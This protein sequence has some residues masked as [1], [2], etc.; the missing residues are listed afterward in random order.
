D[1]R[2][3][4]GLRRHPG[5]PADY[6]WSRCQRKLDIVDIVAGGAKMRALRHARAHLASNF[7]V[8][9]HSARAAR[10]RREKVGP[11][12]RGWCGSIA[13]AW[14]PRTASAAMPSLSWLS[15]SAAPIK[16]YRE[17]GRP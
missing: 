12:K 15:M 9:I 7:Q 11:P 5:V 14:R 16:R 3:D 4:K 10:F 13:A 8:T 1:P 6:D 2:T 17:G